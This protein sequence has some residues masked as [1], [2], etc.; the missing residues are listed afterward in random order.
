MRAVSGATRVAGIIGWPVDASLSPAIHNAAFAAT[1]LDWVYVAFPVHPD[2]IG[3]AIHGMRGLGISGLNVT[4]PHKQSVIAHLDG[5]TADVERVG[6]VNTIVAD[7]KRL[8]GTNTDGPGFIR[9]LE[10]DVSMKPD[11][12]RAVVFGGGGAARGV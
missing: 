5:L 4:M 10:R 12:M 8:I 2:D 1:D 6:A 9:F 3:I 7:G 11:G